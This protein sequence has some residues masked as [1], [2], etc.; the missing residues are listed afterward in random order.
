MSKFAVCRKSVTL[1]ITKG[2]EC[3]MLKNLWY[4]AYQISA[5]NTSRRWGTKS[6]L[7]FNFNAQ[8]CECLSTSICIVKGWKLDFTNKKNDPYRLR[9][10]SVFLSRF[11][12]LGNEWQQSGQRIKG[13]KEMLGSAASCLDCCQPSTFIFNNQWAACHVSDGTLKVMSDTFLGNVKIKT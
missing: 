1:S 10:T 11:Y 8:E 7:P 4:V 12:N 3:V 6:D 13:L 9:D 2:G 5:L